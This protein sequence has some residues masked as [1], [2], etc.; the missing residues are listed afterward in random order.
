MS[1][2]LRQ[3]GTLVGKSDYISF[4]LGSPFTGVQFIKENFPLNNS[5]H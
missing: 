1:C 2:T 3:I 5:F 4:L